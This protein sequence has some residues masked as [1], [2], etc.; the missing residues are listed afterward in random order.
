MGLMENSRSAAIGLLL[1]CCF[2]V[3]LLPGCKRQQRLDA[4]SFGPE[5]LEQV[6]QASALQL[7][8][9][10]SGMY[11]FRD[12]SSDEV[13]LAKIQVPCSSREQMVS[14]IEAKEET[15]MGMDLELLQEVEWWHPEK[16]GATVVDHSYFSR[17]GE[18][19]RAILIHEGE[20]CYLY[21]MWVS[22]A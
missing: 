5:H 20:H 9:G 15:S 2:L 8:D 3:V 14:A 6:E 1:V 16:S 13:L 22:I 12:V 11:L 21:V 17:T 10:T 4:H 18:F 19:V 7:P